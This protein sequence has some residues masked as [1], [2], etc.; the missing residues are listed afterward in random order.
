[1]RISVEL[2]MYPLQANYE[3]LILSFIERLHQQHQGLD[4]RTNGLSTQV[5]G[6]YDTVMS[7]VQQEIKISFNS[8][9]PMSI[10]CKILNVDAADYAP[11]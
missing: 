9:V 8:E 1:M 11:S 10:V 4:I 5:F 6:E 7:A 2:S 3:A